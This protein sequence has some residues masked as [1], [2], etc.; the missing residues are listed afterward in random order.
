MRHAHQLSLSNMQTEPLPSSPPAPPHADPFDSCTRQNR[1]SR[2]TESVTF[3]PLSCHFP[4]RLNDNGGVGSLLLRARVSQSSAPTPD[5][6]HQ[7]HGSAF[8]VTE[9][10]GSFRTRSSWR[11]WSKILMSIG[12]CARAPSRWLADVTAHMCVPDRF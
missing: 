8:K 10:S 12:A 9:R 6:S 5:D 7:P 11:D 4:V 1:R 3:S 2:Q